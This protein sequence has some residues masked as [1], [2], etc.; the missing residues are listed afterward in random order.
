MGVVKKA[1]VRQASIEAEKDKP[2]YMP[3]EILFQNALEDAMRPVRSKKI[4][5][6][7]LGEIHGVCNSAGE[8]VEM[9]KPIQV[10]A[11]IENWMTTLEFSIK[12]SVSKKI[13]E[14]Y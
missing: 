12:H 13:F 14:C 2:V 7:D 1:T 9:D 8:Y 6:E 11:A 5:T 10:T 3:P 4:D